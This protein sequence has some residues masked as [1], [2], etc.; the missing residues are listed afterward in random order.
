MTP[1]QTKNPTNTI[2]FMGVSEPRKIGYYSGTERNFAQELAGQELESGQDIENYL[3]SDPNS[4]FNDP[5]FME[6]M[7]AMWDKF[8]ESA[9][10]DFTQTTK[11]CY[12][13]Q[14]H[15]DIAWKWR[16]GQSVK[17]AQLLLE[18]P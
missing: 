12:I 16:L 18:K 13:A 15:I 6:D 9:G 3:E 17:K 14:S 7:S 11:L 2:W 8:I 1:P 10:E 5:D 4:M